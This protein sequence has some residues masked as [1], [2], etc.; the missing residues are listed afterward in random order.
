[1]ATAGNINPMF[2]PKMAAL[3]LIMI[4][5]GAILIDGSQSLLPVI[6]GGL[7]V[8][9]GMVGCYFTIILNR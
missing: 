2:S 6:I 9:A 7:M 8:V 3:Y 4:M 5:F 1:M